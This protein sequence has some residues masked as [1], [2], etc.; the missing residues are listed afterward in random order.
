MCPPRATAPETNPVL[1]GRRGRANGVL[2]TVDLEQALIVSRSSI[3]SS[4]G[5]CTELRR[6]RAASSDTVP[7]T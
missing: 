5:A 3:P 4:S 2:V 6:E 1:L 7:L